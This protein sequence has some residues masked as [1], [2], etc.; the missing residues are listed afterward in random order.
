MPLCLLVSLFPS[1]S[2]SSTGTVLYST[3]LYYTT[4]LYSTV[5]YPPPQCEQCGHHPPVPPSLPPPI[6]QSTQGKRIHTV[7]VHQVS[8]QVHYSTVQYSVQYNTVQ[9][10]VQ[11]NTVH[12]MS[13]PP[14][15]RCLKE[16]KKLGIG[17]SQEINTLFRF[18][19]FFL[20]YN[21]IPPHPFFDAK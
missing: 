15:T 20:R 1:P 2:V 21:N 10:S 9:Y 19:S 7:A 8:L 4:V 17:H 13:D 16:R 5:Q 14:L 6:T 12:Y 3:V 11:Y 18:W